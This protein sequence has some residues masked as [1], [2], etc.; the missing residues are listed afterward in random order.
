MSP[1]GTCACPAL[2]PQAVVR[3]ELLASLGQEQERSV[4]KKVGHP[5]G[6]TWQGGDATQLGS[7]VL[8]PA[9]IQGA[10]C[11]HSVGTL[12]PPQVC[13]T[14]SELASELVDV[15]GVNQWPEVLPFLMQMIG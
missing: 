7:A 8:R 11:V 14:V 3:T 5:V 2:P 12:R 10:D 4:V 9:A 6:Q 13:D 1:P 15:D